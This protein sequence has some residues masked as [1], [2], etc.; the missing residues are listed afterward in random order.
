MIYC[1]Q[2]QTKLV[3]AAYISTNFLSTNYNMS[4]VKYCMCAAKS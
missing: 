2:H 1:Q 3:K 4:V